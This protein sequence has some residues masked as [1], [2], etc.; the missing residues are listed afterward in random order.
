MSKRILIGFFCGAI[1]LL[2]QLYIR[3]LLIGTNPSV[4]V[5]VGSL[6]N[7]FA[8]IALSLLFVH[9]ATSYKL[10]FFNPNSLISVFVTLGVVAYEISPH[11]TINKSFGGTFDYYD[12]IASISGGII[13]YLVEE[14]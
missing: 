11:S 2:D 7:F 9:I 6:S 13:S 14:K 8:A 1:A 4:D 3:P 5:I 10:N 12:I